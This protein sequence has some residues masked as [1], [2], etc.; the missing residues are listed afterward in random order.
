MTLTSAVTLYHV[1]AELSK[2]YP[3]NKVYYTARTKEASLKS[4]YNFAENSIPLLTSQDPFSHIVS[5]IQASHT[6]YEL[7]TITT[8][9]LTILKSLPHLYNLRDCS[10]V[11]NIDLGLNDYSIIPA[12]KDLDFPTF[13][14]N[15]LESLCANGKLAYTLALSNN[16]PVFHFINF[17]SIEE[18]TIYNKELVLPKFD[19]QNDQ[20]I[21]SYQLDDTVEYFKIYPTNDQISSF[22]SST[23]TLLINLS[24]YGSKFAAF[25]NKLNVQ[26]VDVLIYRPWTLSQL[27]SSLPSSITK[28]VIV[29]GSSK[30][31]PTQGTGFNPLLLDFFDNFT[32]LAERKIDQ[33]VLSNVGTLTDIESAL[34]TIVN[35]VQSSTPNHSLY[36]GED[37]STDQDIDEYTQAIRNVVNLETAYIKVLKQLFDNNLNIIN[38]YGNDTINIKTPEYGFG[39][40][41]KNDHDRDIL[42]SKVKQSIDPTLFSTIPDPNEFVKLL[43]KWVSFNDLGLNESQLNEANDLANQVFTILQDNQDCNAVL[44]ILE[45]APTLEH[46]QFKSNWLVGSD[47][48]SYDLGY[49]G[50]HHVLASKKNINM[51]IIDSE[52]YSEIKNRST[53]NHKKNVGLYAMNFHDVYVASVAVYSSYTQLL[54]AFIEASSFHGPSIVL[55]YLPYNSERDTPL[56]VLK[57][58]KNA[59]GSGYWPLYRYDPRKEDDSTGQ[60]AFTLDSSIIRKELEDFLDRENKLTLLMRNSP[61]LARDLQ[62]SATDFITRKQENRAKAAYDE[63]LEGLFGPP[64]HI[65]YASDGGNAATVATRLSKRAISVGLKA[66]VLSMD[67]IILEDLAGEENVVFVTSTAGQGEFPQDGRTFWEE[68]KAATDLDLSTLNFAVFGLGDSQY[69]PRKED[70]RYYNK[71]AKDLFARLELLAANALTPLGLGDDQDTDGFQTGYNEWE[72]KLWEALGVSA[73]SIEEEKPWTNEDIKSNSNFLRG[74]IAESLADESTL[75]I[76]PYDSQLTKFHGCYIQD[77][78]DLREIR[79]LQGIEP[80]Y[81]FMCRIR[82]PGGVASPDQWLIMDQLSD[83]TGNGTMKITTRA[84]LQLHGILKKNIKHAIRA[85]NS[86]LLDTLAAC[87]DVNRN[88]MVTALPANA[89]VHKQVSKMGYDI[90]EY[91]LP[92]TTAYYDLWLH[93]P[94]ERDEDPNWETLFQSRKSGPN[95][96]KTKLSD[97]SL[98]DIEPLYSPVYLPRKFKVNITVPPYNDVDVWSSDVGLIAIV[99]PKTDDVVGYNMYAGGGMGTTHNNKKTYP[100]RGSLLGFVKSEDIISAIRSVFIVQRDNGSRTD[101]KHARLKYTIDDMGVEVFKEKV[102]EIFGKKFGPEKPFEIKSNCDYFGWVKDETGMNHFTAFVENGRIVDTPD[103]PQKTGFR[104][105]AEYLKKTGSGDFRLT[106]NQ[107]IL[108]CNITDEHLDRVKEIMHKYGID[109]TDLSGIRQTSTSCVGLPT[110]GLAMT[111]S[112]RYLPVLITQLEDILEEYGL[113]HDSIVTRMTGCPNGC[114]RPWLAEL[115]FIGKAPNTYNIMLG[116]GYYGERLNKLYRASVKD[117]DIVDIVRP[118]FKRWAL[119][120]NEGEHFGDFCIRAGI[121]KPTLEGKYFHDDISEEAY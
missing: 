118:L 22:S 76:H 36:L 70:A 99:D 90:S 16:Q 107:H 35:N 119:E 25:T 89:K 6:N 62:L 55:A 103:K 114:S 78:R 31:H 59:V 117:E 10:I 57:E 116:G 14:S 91:F 100:R 47:A 23:T 53:N 26:L 39:G 95:R 42:L 37:L 3:R 92:N 97:N 112:E 65:Y 8:D 51:L 24:S 4:K 30:N 104:T 20:P 56:E 96:K 113:R 79:K 72:P 9:Q 68:L 15:N 61:E 38:E 28:I 74:T 106:G 43:S 94:D 63:L 60:L 67:N 93:G 48:W 54:T 82:L 87:G 18:N 12:L 69:W 58:T 46:F 21:P 75:N 73:E 17:D 115:A 88:V 81:A 50:V 1:L 85:M 7:I 32:L 86:R 66:T 45:L 5:E 34:T 98:V 121:I 41:L 29:E 108:I 19:L 105:V 83:E 40:F 13:I 110:C 101:R 102:E 84:T 2:L 49:S 11:I 77:D 52:P 111:E 27:L 71:P 120:R 64:L 44:Q 33:I 109:N 80:L